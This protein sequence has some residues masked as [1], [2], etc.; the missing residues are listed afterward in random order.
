M[1]AAKDFLGYYNEFKDKIFNYLWYRV[2]FNRALAEDLTSEVFIKA[3]S[4]FDGFDRNRPF[5]AWIYKIARNHL[6]NHYRTCNREVELEQAAHLPETL[7][8]LDAALEVEKLMFE[9][10]KLEPYHRDVLLMR[11]VDGLTNS[12]IA[13]VLEKEEGAVRTQISRALQI[14]KEK[15]KTISDQ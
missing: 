10:E 7:N 11:F 4:S 6:I 13:A 9:I 15:F 3:L 1:D 8:K 14:I 5:Q 12:E 2:N